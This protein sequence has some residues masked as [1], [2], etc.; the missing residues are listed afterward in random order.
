[1]EIIEQFLIG[2]REDPFLNE[3]SI[4]SN[5]HFVAVI[6]GATSKLPNLDRKSPGKIASEL[7]CYI[8]E[9]SP[10]HT[11]LADLIDQINIAFRKMY[12]ENN[13]LDKVT[14]NPE[15]RY[16]ASAI[17]YSNHCKEVWLI[18]DCQGYV[19][20]EYLSNNKEID[21]VLA[22]VRS[23]INTIELKKGKTIASLK[24]NDIGRKEIFPLLKKQMLFQNDI[25]RTPYSYYVIDGFDFPIE[26]VKVYQVKDQQTEIILASDGYPVLEKTLAAS[27]QKLM[28][29]IE[30][31]PLLIG[32]YKETKGLELD[33]IS[34][35]DRAY[36]RF[37]I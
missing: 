30:T 1:M 10:S 35:D 3:D 18:G 21:S 6:D 13:V 8:L 23:F 31:D 33:N 4:F 26:E 7:I 12:Q 9:H 25:D 37:K 28:E 19:N 27:E 17:I 2:K 29:I 36:I 34:F 11:T 5:E 15:Y 20:N 22:N 32:N 24:I 14:D 16:T